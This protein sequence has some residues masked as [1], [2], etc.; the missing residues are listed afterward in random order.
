M[1]LYGIHKNCLEDL[2][3]KAEL[4]SKCMDTKEGDELGDWD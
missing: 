1:H 4:G 2:I 3:C